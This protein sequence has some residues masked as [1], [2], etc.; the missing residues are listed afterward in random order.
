M[1]KLANG[2]NGALTNGHPSSWQAKHDLAPHFIGGNHLD[3]APASAV[4]DFVQKYDG[5]S[6]ITSVGK[7]TL[8][9][10]SASLLTFLPSGAHRQQWHC[11]SQRNQ[12]RTKMGIPD[13]W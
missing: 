5:H 12:I 4:K 8:G 3:A 10:L 11:S 13:V 6:V 9:K 1:P 7:T 2:T